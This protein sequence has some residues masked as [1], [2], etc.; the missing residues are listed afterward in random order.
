M[1]GCSII[2]KNIGLQSYPCKKTIIFTP[3]DRAQVSCFGIE[4]IICIASEPLYGNNDKWFFTLSFNSSLS[5]ARGVVLCW[6]FWNFSKTL[7]P[8]SD[9][10]SVGGKLYRET[11]THSKDN[12]QLNMHDMHTKRTIFSNSPISCYYW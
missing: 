2:F 5:V 11:V 1:I 9:I 12:N 7:L 10:H 8:K 6:L 3:S 4:L